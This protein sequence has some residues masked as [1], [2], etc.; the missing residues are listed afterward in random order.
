MQVNI[1]K[2][3]YGEKQ[4]DIRKLGVF[5]KFNPYFLHPEIEIYNRKIINIPFNFVDKTI[6]EDDL[7]SDFRDIGYFNKILRTLK[8]CPLI[9]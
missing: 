8:G 9:I 7:V 5:N 2:L 4:Y 1:L 3:T 6:F